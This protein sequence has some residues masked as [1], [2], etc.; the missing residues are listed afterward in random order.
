VC[1]VS[2]LHEA[3]GYQLFCNRDERHTRRPALP[4]R[5][6]ERAGVKF[7]APADGD[8]GGSWIAVNEFGLSLCLLNRY[9]DDPPQPAGTF[10]SRGLLLLD[11]I[12]SRSQAE[13]ARRVSAAALARFRPFTLAAL[14]P[15]RPALLFDWAGGELAVEPAG[16]ARMP[17][18][19]SSYDTAGVSA[20]RAR[21]FAGLTAAGALGAESL[22]G[23]HHSHEPERG[24]SSVCMHRPDAQTV[25]FSRV[26]VAGEAIEF[27][28][29]PGPPCA[30]PEAGGR[31]V[32]ARLK[33]S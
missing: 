29:Q 30:G 33:R 18:T 4:P 13:A 21:Q 24:H 16:D 12:T 23:F 6:R 15:G 28:Y 27:E 1:T 31:A 26:V 32:R 9:Q 14:A 20:A 2:W 5:R 8:H 11:V 10:V 22:R 25:S 17:L 3:A 7:I 19:S